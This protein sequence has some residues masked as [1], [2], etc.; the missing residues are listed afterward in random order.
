M[1]YAAAGLGLLVFVF[2]I[3]RKSS[4]S[5]RAVTDA[6]DRGI[7][8]AISRVEA[9]LYAATEASEKAMHAA[10]LSELEK[11]RGQ[12]ARRRI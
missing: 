1:I 6:A 2:G 9:K 4:A 5:V 12:A 8:T 11:A 3:I 10:T 7:A